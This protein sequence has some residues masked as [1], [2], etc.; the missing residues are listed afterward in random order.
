MMLDPAKP[1]N[2]EAARAARERQDRLTKPPGALG[3]LEDV[4][5]RLAAMQG[6]ETPSA[7]K[8]HITVFAADHGVAAQG[9]SAFPQSVTAEMVRNFARGGAAINV[10]ARELGATLEVVDFGT[11]DVLEPLQG[12]LS[13]RLGPGTADF[14]QGPAMTSAQLQQAMAGG[15]AAVRRAVDAGAHLFIGGEMGIGNTTA[16]AAVASALLNVP[17]AEIVGAGTGLDANGIGHKQAVI[18]RAL[19]LHALALHDPIEVLR[20]MGGFEIAG[21]SGACLAA[22]R[23]G[24]PMF[25]DG[26]I[27]SVAALVATRLCPETRNWLLF[28][29]ASAERGHAL[30]LK[31]LDAQPLLSLG[32]RLGEGSG[33]AV[34]VPLLRMAC[35]LHNNMATFADAGV[36][37]KLP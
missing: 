5:I 28:G 34:A 23:L 8:V 12:V 29:H 11:V 14:A 37:E 24:M 31:A 3:L 2:A 13:A 27:C 19:A 33:A 20:R 35:A 30:V 9:V 32:M 10:A 36:S 21:L 17:P 16:A 6:T 22:A 4:A 1:L 26:F 7:E 25:V 18:E 15:D